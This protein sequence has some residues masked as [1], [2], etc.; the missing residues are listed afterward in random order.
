MVADQP[1]QVQVCMSRDQ[2]LILLDWLA[3]S[4]S[5]EQ[6]APFEDQAEQRALWDLESSLESLIP[7]VLDPHYRDEVLAAR[8]RVR[9][10]D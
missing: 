3:R 6:P 9:D 4:S 10:A 8:E 7:E 1:E 2:A 5:V